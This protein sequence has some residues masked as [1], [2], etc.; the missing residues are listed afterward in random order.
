MA[1]GVVLSLVTLLANVGLLAMSGWFISAMAIAGAA[2]VSM[3]YFTPAAF[4]RA[5]AMLRTGGRYLERLV[6][7]EATLRL[8]S[9]LRVWFYRHLEPLAPARL[10]RYHSGDLLSRIRADIDTL[11]NF[12]LRFL[13][14]VAVALLGATL[15]FLFLWRY[16]PTLALI[17][18]AGLVLAGA[19]LPAWL[20]RQGREPGRRQVETAARL[21]ATLVDSVQGLG[22]LS[23]YGAGPT[24]LA[25]IDT[26]SRELINEQD[27]MSRL[28][29]ISQGALG[30]AANLTLWLGLWVAVPLTNQGRLAPA[31]LAMLSLFVLA[32]FEAVMPLSL[33]FQHLGAT[34]T[35]ARRLFSL[36]DA[37]PAVTEPDAP[38]P[39]PEQLDLRLRGVTF[40]YRDADPPALY[41]LDLDLP[42]AGRVAVVGATGSGKS[43]LVN[44]VLRFWEPQSGEIR[45]GDYPLSA[46][47]GEDLRRKVAVVS[48][49]THL[50]NTTVG[51]NLLLANPDAPRA[52]L[53]Q[54]CRTAQIHDFIASQPD[55]YDTW[56]GEAGLKLSGGQAR[57]VAIA[58]ALL[59]DAP[60]LILDEPTEGLDAPTERELM[61]ALYRLME[62]RSVLL[63]THRLVGV[64]A[65]DEIL[66][67]EQG[68]VVERGDHATLLARRGRYR[69]MRAFLSE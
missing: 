63:I 6:T 11:D 48:Q 23:V 66:V 3:N 64:E 4:I 14:P 69:A 65:F 26:L 7:H 46:F 61:A 8:L 10:Q 20:Q 50:F 55:G 1:L 45:L 43:T 51:E 33:A 24:Q 57:R 42:T 35:A 15:F 62:G 39:E 19:L 60:I 27:R 32:S 17:D 12:Y 38:S 22:E 44:L 36:I 29:G 68:R 56:V 53:E 16:H 34:L 41:D 52:A 54:A 2:Q 21:R 40:R 5:C 13:V 58:Q 30:L 59:K 67:L 31:E 47:R 9:S 25:S 28:T 49:H 37:G 18:L